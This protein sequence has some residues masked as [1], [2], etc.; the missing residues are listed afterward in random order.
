MAVA[1][2]AS[3]RARHVISAPL[4]DLS[5]RDRSAALVARTSKTSRG[6]ARIA[7]RRRIRKTYGADGVDWRRCGKVVART[8]TR[9][10]GG[11]R[12]HPSR[13]PTAPN[14]TAHLRHRVPSVSPGV[15]VERRG[16]GHKNVHGTQSPKR[17]ECRYLERATSVP[18]NWRKVSELTSRMSSQNGRAAHEPIAQLCC[19]TPNVDA[20]TCLGAP[21]T[22]FSRIRGAWP[23]GSPAGCHELFVRAT[24][25]RL[26]VST[27]PLSP[28]EFA[29]CFF[30]LAPQP[31]LNADHA[32]R[33]WAD[34][35][36]QR[37]AARGVLRHPRANEVDRGAPI[38]RSSAPCS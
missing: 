32:P 35:P 21:G 26:P 36:T 19:P 23:P 18:I 37:V 27:C 7:D 22:T 15:E 30:S 14:R 31:S 33:L 29:S 13:R 4:D 20:N 6:G 11:Q 38:R 34:R 16:G 10:P 2:R 28:C 24:R 1:C 3:H 17:L 5:T 25:R 8:P 12:R 9:H